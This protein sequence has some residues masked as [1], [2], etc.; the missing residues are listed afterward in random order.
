MVP[1]LS[2]LVLDVILR[3][4]PSFGGRITFRLVDLFHFRWRGHFCLS[5]WPSTEGV[6]FFFPRFRFIWHGAESHSVR[7]LYRVAFYFVPFYFSTFR[8]RAHAFPFHCLLSSICP[9]A[10]SF[11]FV[12]ISLFL[13]APLTKTSCRPPASVLTSY[14][15][16]LMALLNVYHEFYWVSSSSSLY[17]TN[18]TFEKEINNDFGRY[19]PV[20]VGQ[21]SLRSTGNLIYRV[22][23]G[24]FVLFF[25]FTEFSRVPPRESARH[26]HNVTT[27]FLF[28]QG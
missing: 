9:F 13:F 24:F 8:R 25:L 27:T 14:F 21:C 12:F 3:K 1:S 6:L 2:G 22:L 19:F 20:L 11:S 17:E 26:A 4:L 16:A 23:P 28:V 15:L 5:L 18:S 10:F 7:H